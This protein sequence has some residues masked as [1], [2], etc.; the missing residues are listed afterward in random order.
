M[1][2]LLPFCRRQPG[3]EVSDGSDADGGQEY[4]GPFEYDRVG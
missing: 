2:K 4:V 1:K 3:D